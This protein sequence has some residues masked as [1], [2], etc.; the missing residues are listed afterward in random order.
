MSAR[1]NGRPS[2]GGRLARGLLIALPLGGALVAALASTASGA[3]FGASVSVSAPPQYLGDTAGTTFTFT[4][5]NTGTSNRIGAVEIRRPSDGWTVVACPAGPAG[6]KR[7]A[8][9]SSC[10]YTSAVSAADDLAPKAAKTFQVKA[11]SAQGRTNRTGTWRAVVS[12]SNGFSPAGNVANA[13]PTTTTSMTSTVFTW[14]VVSAPLTGSTA[15]GGCPAGAKSAHAG[16]THTAVV[17]ARNHAYTRL[18]PVKAYSALGGT[19]VK[20]PGGY[21]AVSAPARSGVLGVVHWT[22]T[23]LTSTVGTGKTVAV[24]IGSAAN[25][26]SPL[27]TLTGY[28]ATNTAPVAAADAASGAEETV[29]SGSV[30]GN[31]SDADGDAI[32]A[33]VAA[34]PSHGSVDLDDNG[35]FTYTPAANFAGP[36][37]FTYTASDGFTSSTPATVTLTVDPVNDGPAD[38]VPGAQTVGEDRVLTFAIGTNGVSVADVDSAASDI[39]VTLTV[40]NGTL[41]PSTDDGMTSCTGD[42]TSTLVLVGPLAAVNTALDGLTYSPNANFHGA[43]TLTMLTSDLGH[44]GSGGAL[45]D[46]DTVA[47]TVSSVNDEPSFVKGADQT[48]AE[49]SGAHTV[50]GWATGT[51][52]GPADE[53]GQSVEFLVV[54]NDT[55]GLFTTQPAVATNGDLTYTLAADAFGT[56]TVTVSAHDNGGTANGGD[57]LGS[58]TLIVTATPVND[59]PS[60]TNAGNLPTVGED[61][62][63]QTLA[64]WATNVSK[65]PANESGQTLHFTVTNDGGG[66]FSTEPAVAADGTLTYTT[67]PN[68]SGT[69]N[70][71]ATLA[72]D[73]DTTGG[74]SDTSATV[75]VTLTV[76]AVNDAPTFTM[77]DDQTTPEDSEPQNVATWATEIS[78]GPADESQTVDF[79]VTNDTNAMFSAQPVV[80]ANGDLTYTPADNAFGVV[81]V[82]VK[83]HDVDG[84]ADTSEP[85]TFTITVSPVNDT[86]AFTKGGDQTVDEDAG[87]QTVTG[88]ATGISA[89]PPNESGQALTFAASRGATTRSRVT[90]VSNDTLFS[91]VP[92][93]DAVTGDLTFT[94]APDANGTASLTV[95]LSDDG[96]GDDTSAPQTFTITVNA[97][98]DPP[99]FAA[100]QNTT[101]LEDAGYTPVGGWATDISPGPADESGQTLTLTVTHNTNG[102]LFSTGPDIDVATGNLTYTPAPDAVG[103]AQVTVVLSDDGGG[104][105]SSDPVTFSITVTAVNDAPSFSGGQ[106]QT[107]QEDAGPQT[108]GGWATGL[109]TGP[110]DESGQT[111]MLAVTGVSNTGLFTA[112]PSVDPVTGDLTYTPAPDAS[113]STDF[114]V[115]PSDD[116]GTADSG[117]NTGASGTF[118]IEV[119]AVNDPPSFTKGPDQMVSEDAGPQTVTGWANGMTTGAADESGQT[120]SFTVTS[121][122]NGPLFSAGP[123]VDG[124]TGDLTFTPAENA[125]G[126]ADVTL[127]LYDNGGGA[128]TS[129]PQT[130]SIAVTAVN[131]PPVFDKDADPESQEDAG[132]QTVSGWASG[133][134]AGGADESG[135]ALGFTVTMNAG[136]TLFSTGPSVDSTTGDLTYTPAPDANG[137]ADV[138]LTLA[139]DG[140]GADTNAPQ[141]F[142]ITVTPVNDAPSFTNGPDRTVS[143]DA[144]PQT[145]NGWATDIDAG[146]ADESGQTLTFTVS[147]NTG[148]G[149]FSVWPAVDAATGDLTFTPAPDANGT[150][151]LTVTL[152]DNGGSDDTSAPHPLSITVTAVNDAPAFTKGADQNVDENSGAQTVTDWA[153]GISTGP[154]DESGQA[155]TFP[156]TGNTTPTLFSTAPAVDAAGTL[157][158]TI[159]DGQTG[160]STITL[161]AGDS[162]GTLDG[163]DDT[164]DDQTFTITVNEPQGLGPF[165]VDNFALTDEDG[166]IEIT[167]GALA[168]GDVTFSIVNGPTHGSLG[169]VGAA[170][171]FFIFCGATVT[172]TPGPD[173]NGSD[174]FTFKVNDGVNDGN[175]A[176]ISIT[177]LPMQDAPTADGQ[178]SAANNGTPVVLTLSGSDV[179]DENLTFSIATGPGLGS[180]GAFSPPDCTAVNVCTATVTYT[181]T[182]GASGTDTFTFTVNDGHVDSDAATVTIDV[183]T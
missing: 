101:A 7:T 141:T 65:G 103:V 159:A 20:T 13:A 107:V 79:I 61:A 112:G 117:F 158:Y 129:A 53:A 182:E 72:D 155:V 146:P 41:A 137:S 92:A 110:P 73:G 8:T 1:A 69:A 143:E 31:D 23:T 71:T 181:P 21:D 44:T 16:T 24:R 116:G 37:S 34:Q 126:T 12:R 48:V 135:Q 120:L 51:S 47:I 76:G 105:D 10:R 74:G 57:D 14:Q 115:T 124:V 111:L 168:L 140:G 178:T 66:L 77:G 58:D 78:G 170:N 121:N 82:T 52:P 127:T 87:P 25:Q 17:C 109:S 152:S 35:S 96:G 36:D 134:S 142:T 56:A 18:A 84:G 46:T 113:G 100:G 98:N 157:T 9:A 80:A 40:T 108:V 131:D 5:K 114:T 128:D 64:S 138:T 70:V 94:P 173:Y 171:C 133:I 125:N 75:T 68:A 38:T 148:S 151:D 167:L 180:V 176:T 153:T 175:T 62:G 42:D 119:T 59:A 166:S 32:D 162:G 177:V 149:L 60:F 11:T 147:G 172:Y 99:T 95:T 39:S 144:G 26:T 91:A 43:D 22:G 93:I 2:R 156:I 6:W 164:S 139:D 85:Q 106:N 118:S 122:T 165:A 19:M 163:G 145:V 86:P 102:A 67:A 150:A 27:T 49:D 154:A 3:A 104:A 179:D 174:S 97:V 33:T 132:P 169:E 63:A 161:H 15:F 30:L 88:W 89:G 28:A 123:D 136:T 54:V 160:S 4:V 183:A 130:F 50:I 45:T 90:S 81:T 83:A 55:N 29:I